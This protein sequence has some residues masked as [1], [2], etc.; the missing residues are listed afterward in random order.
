MT[1]AQASSPA[2]SSRG[3]GPLRAPLPH[4]AP[5]GV[6]LVLRV[7]MLVFG[8][9]IRV[10]NPDRLAAVERGCILALNHNNYFE[11]VLVPSALV[12][13]TGGIRTAFLADWMF[14]DLPLVGWFLRQVGCIPVYRKRARW[15]YREAFRRRALAATDPLERAR[16][17]LAAGGSVG[18]F[19]EGK[20]NPSV[21]R[22]LRLRRG[23]TTLAINAG[24]P[25]LPIG[26]EFAGARRRGSMPAFGVMHVR[27]GEILQ[28]PS[29]PTASDAVRRFDE[30][31][32]KAL[33]ALSGK[34]AP[35]KTNRRAGGWAWIPRSHA[36]SSALRRTARTH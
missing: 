12:F 26:I 21:D 23:V 2:A 10:E 1:I 16:E 15:G 28:P 34:S 11:T 24:V 4:L 14:F 9:F 25:V 13:A 20:R 17:I 36:G 29:T 3:W 7:L 35:R 31:L 18:V 27:I 33:S 5:S 8:R 19:P 32:T 30:D 22:L 6:R